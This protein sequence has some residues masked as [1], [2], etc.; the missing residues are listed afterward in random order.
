LNGIRGILPGM[1][2]M[3]NLA[4]GFGAVVIAGSS[5]YITGPERG[6]NLTEAAWLIIL[7]GFL[8]FLDGMVARFSRSSSRLGVEMDSLADIVSF[9]VAP[10]VVII[11]FSL[12]SKGNWA[13]ILAF[14]YLMAGSFRLARFS[15]SA[16]LEEKTNFVGLPIPSAA[17]AIVSYI[18]F[19][20]EVWGGIRFEKFFIILIIASAAL[21]VSTIEYETM[22]KFDIS[23]TKDRIKILFLLLVA[24]GMMI[25][26]SLVMFPL[27]MGYILFGLSRMI[28]VVFTG[29]GKVTFTY[30]P[31]IFRKGEREEE[32]EV[33]Q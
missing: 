23:R 6:H 17:I 19:C 25:N 11:G 30:P 31:M 12:I 10:A 29:T 26:A 32:D 18:L 28:Y 15:L 5:K 7:A 33:G 8:D 16:T 20:T 24:V 13:W 2:T 21:M 1:F 14:V 22:P 3:G 4:C 27:A 9:G